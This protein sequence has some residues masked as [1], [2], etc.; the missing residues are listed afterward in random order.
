MITKRDILLS[1]FNN[2]PE[3]YQTSAL[4]NVCV[5]QLLNG[6]D[7]YKILEEVIVM[8]ENQSKEYIKILENGGMR[9][10]IIISNEK[11]GEVK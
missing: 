2:G 7:I 4:F 5:H 1:R 9:T 8:K 10:Q 11:F 3:L 6:H